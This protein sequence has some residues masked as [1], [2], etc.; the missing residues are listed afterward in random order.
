MKT[1]VTF[2]ETARISLRTLILR[3][4]KLSSPAQR[5]PRC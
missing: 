1:T 3:L 5:W 4:G 2:P